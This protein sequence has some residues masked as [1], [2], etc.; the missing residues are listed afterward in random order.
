MSRKRRI[1]FVKNT[2]RSFTEQDIEILRSNFDVCVVNF[3]SAKKDAFKLLRYVPKADASF[4]WFAGIHAFLAILV[5]KIFGRKSILVA[6]GYDVANEPSINYGLMRFP[7]SIPARIAKFALRHADRV[8]AVSEFNKSEALRYANP[9]KVELVYNA[10][11]C[12]KFKPQGEKNKDLVITVG[13]VTMQTLKK[14]GLEVFVNTAKYLPNIKFILIGQAY[15]NSIELLKAIAPPNVEFR[16]YIP[17]QELPKWYQKAKVY[18]QL[19]YHESFGLSLA[20]AMACG[21]VPVIT[22][23][24]AL[25]ELVGDTGFYVPYGDPKATA[26]AIKEALKSDTGEIARERVKRL[27]SIENRKEALVKLVEGVIDERVTGNVG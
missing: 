13:G 12:D 15:D 5:S 20:E 8:L 18:C 9:K 19:S 26:E 4:I 7:K 1:L 27:F 11:D 23:Q 6:G 24:A 21:C 16:G 10:V 22:N 17:H 2:T 14:K 25:P 3:T